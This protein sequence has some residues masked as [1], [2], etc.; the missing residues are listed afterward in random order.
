MSLAIEGQDY[1]GFIDYDRAKLKTAT[2]D[3]RILWLEYRIKKVLIEPLD[4]VFPPN[5]PCHQAVN[6][7]DKTFNL[8]GI[9]L[10]AC[11]IEGLGHFMTGQSDQNG[12]SF[13]AWL[14]RYMSNWNQT[15]ANGVPIRSWLWD[16]ARN[17][18]A[19]QLTFKRGGTGCHGG[20]R[21]VE[22]GDGQIEMDPFVFYDDFK[23]GVTLFCHDL[24]NNAN[25][26]TNF[27]TR[28]RTTLL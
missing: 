20:K 24:K 4:Q 28:F 11:A 7:G 2:V 27:E 23:A 21:F 16:S 10:V 14:M 13:K 17:G 15:T 19:H 25:I 8:C 1:T 3:A 26:Q 9:T 22:L 5:A 12:D 6:Q 18:L